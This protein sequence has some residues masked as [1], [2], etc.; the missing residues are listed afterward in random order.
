MR[1]FA[2]YERK[3]FRRAYPIIEIICLDVKL[4]TQYSDKKK[5]FCQ[6]LALFNEKCSSLMEKLHK[7]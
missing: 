1:R 7:F 6:A 3:K 2:T 5:N 4:C